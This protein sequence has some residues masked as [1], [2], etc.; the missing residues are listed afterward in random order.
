[1][2]ILKKAASLYGT[3]LYVY[4]ESTIRDRASRVK[5]VFRG[6][7][8]FPTFAVKANNNPVLLKILKEE[9]F[10]MDIVT[11][12]EF[13]ATKLAGVPSTSIVWNGNGKSR[14]DMLYLLEEGVKIVNVDSFEEMEIWK[15]IRPKGVEF[16]VRVNPEVD[17]RTHPHIST[18]LRKHKF[19]IPLDSLDDFMREFCDMNIKGLHVHIGSQITEVEPFLEAYERVVEMSKKYGFEEINIGGGWG[20]DYEGKELDLEE[21]KKCVV[22][23]FREYKRVIVEIGRFVIAPAGFLV[24]KVILV[25]RRGDKVFVVVNGGMNVLIRPAL[26]S[27]HHRVFVLDKGNFSLKADVVGPLCESGDIIAL[28]RYLPD[29]KKGDL[30]VVENTGAYGY[31]MA[32]NYNSTTRPAE[33]LVKKDGTISLIRKR[34]TDLDI[35]RNVVM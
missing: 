13:I 28:D 6:T 30:I 31:S 19:G 14:E 11:R 10:G 32:N 17:A 25:K 9:G 20:I 35:F 34:E 15:E 2:E 21:Y 12:G 18:G 29:V 5:E 24:L 4:F 16:F 1:M 8:L 3:P 33:V 7:N 23:L 27:A 22:P 26:Y